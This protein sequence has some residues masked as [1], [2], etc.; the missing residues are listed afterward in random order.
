MRTP[1]VGKLQ[2]TRYASATGPYQTDAITNPSWEEIETALVR[3][4]RCLFPFVWLYR[5]RD[6]AEDD[7]PQFEVLGGDGA[8]VVAIRPNGSELWLRNP[9]GGPEDVDVWLSD[10]GASFPA[11]QVC[12]SLAEVLR[13]TRYFYL[14]GEPAPQA[15]WG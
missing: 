9:F 11:S 7:V 15:V 12:G 13:V 3:L 2:V 14:F 8:Y 1:A 10:Q 4:D 6:A 5:D